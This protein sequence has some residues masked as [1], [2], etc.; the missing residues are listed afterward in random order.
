MYLGTESTFGAIVAD[1]AEAGV[2]AS[3]RA[4]VRPLAGG[5]SS[6]IFLIDDGVRPVV[7][8]RALAQLRVQQEWVA[9]V[10]RNRYEQAY[11][12]YVA[13]LLPDSVPT[14][15]HRDTERGYFV[16]EY[17]GDGYV[18]WKSR[19]L[20]LDVQT[21]HAGIAGSILGTIHRH[22]WMDPIARGVFDSDRNF[23][24]LRL[25][26]YLLTTARNHS[27][28]AA[29]IEVEADRIAR[30]REC[31]VHGDFS[32]KNLLIAD[33]ADSSARMVVLDCEVA[34]FGDA[35]FDVAFLL[36]H[37]MLKALHLPR[38]RAVL[39]K[40]VLAAL[41]AYKNILRDERVEVTDHRTAVLLPMLMLARID[42]KSPV[43]YLND[44][45]RQRV[46]DFSRDVIHQPVSTVC[47]LVSRWENALGQ[48]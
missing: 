7:V 39:L 15:Y 8:K 43:E 3:A 48:D 6:D 27:D 45:E 47:D 37:L 40:S 13:K 28:I 17:I 19:L 33:D 41:D 36:N 46:R 29:Q 10:S 26:P 23:Y 30:S 11:I 25:E 4:E 42:G 34:W 22:S 24:E 5:V 20:A 31:L 2:I 21:A 35:A 38:R 14:I 44:T 18:T 16:M 9:D 12:D 32:P 1:L